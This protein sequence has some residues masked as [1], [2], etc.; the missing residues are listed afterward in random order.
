MIVL[1]LTGT[2]YAQTKVVSKTPV[3]KP[4][5]LKLD[6]QGRAYYF[7]QDGDKVIVLDYKRR[8]SLQAVSSYKKEDLDKAKMVPKTFY[9]ESVLDEVGTVKPS[10]KKYTIQEGDTWQGISLKLYDTEDQWAQ[11]KVWNEELLKD[12]NLP[13]GTEMKYMELPNN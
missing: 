10:F 12:P 3:K 11:L 6:A 2:V 1:V 5:S 7:D 9:K 8:K 13:A 4:V